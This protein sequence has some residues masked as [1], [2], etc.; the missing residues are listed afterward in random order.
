MACSFPATKTPRL[1]ELSINPQLLVPSQAGVGKAQPG[2]FLGPLAKLGRSP[3][4][5]AQGPTHWVRAELDGCGVLA[6]AH[7]PIALDF[8]AEAVAATVQLCVC[9]VALCF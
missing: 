1:S 4:L 2:P 7:T 9:P 5:A 8:A 3:G 6:A